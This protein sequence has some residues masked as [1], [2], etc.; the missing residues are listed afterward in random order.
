MGTTIEDIAKA[1]GVSSA[2]VSRVLN[3]P[4]MVRPETIAKVT[5]VIEAY[6]YKPS[7]F[8]RGLMRSRTDSVGIV[9]P[10]ITNP[11]FT[12][13]VETIESALARNGTRQNRTS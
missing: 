8:A 11:Y 4:E 13:V 6:K 3:S 9:V 12:A 1:A 10:N 7:I 5:S 2:T